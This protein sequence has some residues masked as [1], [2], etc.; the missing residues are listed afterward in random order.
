MRCKDFDDCGNE[1]YE[2][3]IYCEACDPACVES[4][5]SEQ[6]EPPEWEAADRWYDELKDA[7]IREA[8]GDDD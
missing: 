6:K 8:W 3:W 1:A 4:D 5:D 7:R 2:G